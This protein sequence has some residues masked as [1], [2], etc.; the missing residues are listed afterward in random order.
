MSCEHALNALQ[1]SWC[2]TPWRPAYLRAP[3]VRDRIRWV[4][5]VVNKAIQWSDGGFVLATVSAPQS[6][7]HRPLGMAH[8]PPPMG[9][10]SPYPGPSR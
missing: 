9:A 6:T 3:V 10:V 7:T 1:L 2:S 8:P 4:T 5:R